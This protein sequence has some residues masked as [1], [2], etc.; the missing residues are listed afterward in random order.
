MPALPYPVARL[1]DAALVG[2]LTVIGADDRPIT[3]PMIPLLWGDRIFM[4][5]SALDS[6]KVAHIKANPR[7]SFSVTNADAIGTYAGKVT[8]QCDARVAE[9]DLHAGWERLLDNWKR[10]DPSVVGLLKSRL[11]FP[12]LFERVLIELTPRRTW[13]W[14]DGRTDRAPQVTIAAEVAR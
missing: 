11:G 8:I 1:I 14:P 5:S 3:Y 2:E 9:D 7:V 12:L 4:T 6:A 13:F 10:K